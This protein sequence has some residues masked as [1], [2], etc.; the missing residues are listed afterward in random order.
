VNLQCLSDS[1]PPRRKT[2]SIDDVGPIYA[3]K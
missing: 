1:Q 3:P 2:Q